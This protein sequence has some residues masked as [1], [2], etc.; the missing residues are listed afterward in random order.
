MAPPFNDVKDME[1]VRMTM[2]F[3]ILARAELR[4]IPS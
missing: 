1:A 4:G 2:A 3:V